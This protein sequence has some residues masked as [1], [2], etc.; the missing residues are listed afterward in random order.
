M[1]LLYYFILGVISDCNIVIKMAQKLGLDRRQPRMYATNLVDCCLG[2]EC[3]NGQVKSIYWVSLGLDGDVTDLVY[4]PN[5]RRLDLSFNELTG[6]L[7][8]KLPSDFFA[9]DYNRLNEIANVTFPP[10]L[11]Y[12]SISG[13]HLVGQLNFDFF[14]D[15]MKVSN[16]KL[17]GKLP[18]MVGTSQVY[19]DKNQFNG[20]LANKLSDALQFGSFDYNLFSGKIEVFPTQ[21]LFISIQ[22]NLLSGSLP[23]FPPL[24]Y[25]LT[26]SNNLFIGNIPNL[27]NLGILRLDNNR[28]S[29]IFEPSFFNIIELTIKNNNLT[30]NMSNWISAESVQNIDIS[31]NHFYGEVSIL[32]NNCFL[33][34]TNNDVSSVK[35]IDGTCSIGDIDNY[36]ILKNNPIS[37]SSNLPVNCQTNK[38]SKSG[39]GCEQLAI[40][41]K[42]MKL[43]LNKP[44]YFDSI[45]QDCCSL[46]EIYCYERIVLEITWNSFN[47][48]EPEITLDMDLLPKGLTIL[49][50]SN[51]NFVNIVGQ[52]PQNLSFIAI[53]NNKINGSIPDFA[54]IGTISIDNNQFSGQITQ[55]FMNALQFYING[56][57]FN[58]TMPE[59]PNAKYY[60][61]NDNQFSGPIYIPPNADSIFVQNNK[62]SGN[63]PGFG[64][65]SVG[66]MNHNQL[67]GTI[68]LI[69][70]GMINLDLS[71]NQFTNLTGPF[72]TSLAHLFLQSNKINTVLP[73]LPPNMITLVLGLP[74]QLDSNN[75]SGNVSML[76]L[77]SEKFLYLYN[78]SISNVY[79]AAPDTLKYC[80]ITKNPILNATN[81]EIC[82]N[83]SDSFLKQNLILSESSISS[84][85]N[86]DTLPVT[87]TT[88]SLSDQ[89]EFNPYSI[90]D[91]KRIFYLFRVYFDQKNIFQDYFRCSISLGFH[92]IFCNI[93]SNL[94]NHISKFIL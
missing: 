73:T 4:P 39:Y 14:G 81:L 26:A 76:E 79:I 72:P 25:S 90:D 32:K 84:F 29:G 86:T 12:L 93:I 48:I 15:Y 38:P 18:K 16:N 22:H 13:N 75:F 17:S 33:N 41:A 50:L 63:L 51:N 49:F 54:N 5:L 56:N 9:I 92:Y 91:S 88:I 68:P 67:S 10:T 62:L 21:V 34:I 85:V 89:I 20:T 1:I 83:N 57:K 70:N 69:P 61:A 66:N 78:N 35:V 44:D 46:S 43:D 8:F 7:N 3:S 58:G 11:A 27:S 30:G 42:S 52:V 2:V 64:K 82:A 74:N 45:S 19:C 77:N 80:D 47:S 65:I 87:T 59:A 24:L 28:L 31:N 60:Y 71:F 94:P 40:F 36:C 37:N 53:T 6:I 23:A 55:K